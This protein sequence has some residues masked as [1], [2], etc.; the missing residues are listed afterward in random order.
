LVEDGWITSSRYVS[1]AR[2]Q[3]LLSE[4]RRLHDARWSAGAA[5]LRI[6]R[7]EMRAK[8]M[9][10]NQ[11]SEISSRPSLHMTT[12]IGPKTEP[13]GTHRWADVMMTYS[14]HHG[15]TYCD[16]YLSETV[17]ST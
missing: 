5:L 14:F 12:K 6:I 13:C 16:I 7:V 2:R 15:R 10:L 9:L 1:Y 4:G 17:I 11:R 3:T 8:T